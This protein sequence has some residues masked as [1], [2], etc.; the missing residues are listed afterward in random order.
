MKGHS[1]F[2]AHGTACE[3]ATLQDLDVLL[4]IGDPR[5]ALGICRDGLA[6]VRAL[7][8]R[9]ADARR[10]G[11]PAARARARL[12]LGLV[13]SYCTWSEA[14]DEPP[15]FLPGAHAR[16]STPFPTAP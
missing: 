3:P 9:D 16:L 14:H 2:H 15:L 12:D 11:L 6:A 1:V 7:A 13:S 10:H 8:G 4:R 5:I